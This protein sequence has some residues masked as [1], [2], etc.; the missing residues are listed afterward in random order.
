MKKSKKPS[1]YFKKYF[2]LFLNTF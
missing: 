1:K 2:V